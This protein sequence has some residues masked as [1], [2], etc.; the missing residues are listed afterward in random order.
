MSKVYLVDGNLQDFSGKFDAGLLT[1]AQGTL[2]GAFPSDEFQARMLEVNPDLRGLLLRS[3]VLR[4]RRCWRPSRPSA[5]APPTARPSRRTWRPSRA[6]TAARRAP[7]FEECLELLEAG[8][9][10]DYEAVSG[11]G[12]FNADNDPSSAFIGVYTFN[13]DN[14]YTFSK[15]EFGEVG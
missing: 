1:G 10:I 11:V 2:P 12:P 4:R 9:D 8:E 3:G 6:P 5:A 13:E 15:S 7:A 14:T